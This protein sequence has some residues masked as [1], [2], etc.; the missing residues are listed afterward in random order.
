[1]DSSLLITTVI[2]VTVLAIAVLA[3]VYFREHLKARTSDGSLESLKATLTELRRTHAEALYD[4]ENQVKRLTLD[5]EGK[6]VRFET[7]ISEAI[8]ERTKLSS[9]I[10]TRVPHQRF[11]V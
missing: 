7:A 10:Q 4:M 5:L 2:S 8:G 11:G 1:M 3:F 6:S 9:M